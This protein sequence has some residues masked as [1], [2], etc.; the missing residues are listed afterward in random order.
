MRWIGGLS[1]F[2]EVSRPG[3]VVLNSANDPRHERDWFRLPQRP[4]FRL[5]LVTEPRPS[6]LRRSLRP[7][8]RDSPPPWNEALRPGGHDSPAGAVSDRGRDP[9]GRL[10]AEAQDAEEAPWSDTLERNPRGYDGSARGSDGVPGG[11]SG[12]SRHPDVTPGPLG[13]V[14]RGPATGPGRVRGNPHRVEPNGSASDGPSRSPSTV[15]GVPS[16]ASRGG[17]RHDRRRRRPARG[18]RK[19]GVDDFV[20]RSGR[21]IDCSGPPGSRARR[22]GAAAGLAGIPPTRPGV[23]SGGRGNPSRNRPSGDA[24]VLPVRAS[25]DGTPG[26]PWHPPG[27]ARV[28]SSWPLIRSGSAGHS[29]A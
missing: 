29:H 12:V 25:S 13:E 24:L 9:S 23:P 8:P 22:R 19:H 2:R 15:A 14:P 26:G 7:R 11:F 10:T 18:P 6:R 17:F 4:R 16:T 5:S 27:E 21:Q 28:P 3:P 1:N 20:F